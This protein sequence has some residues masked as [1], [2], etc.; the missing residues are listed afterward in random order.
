MRTDLFNGGQR[1]WFLGAGLKFIKLGHES[2][3]ERI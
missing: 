2:N 3:K 1:P